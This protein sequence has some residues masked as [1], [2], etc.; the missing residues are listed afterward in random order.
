VCS[1]AAPAYRR[2]GVKLCGPGRRPLGCPASPLP[3][4]RLRQATPLYRAQRQDRQLLPLPRRVGRPAPAHPASPA[5][6][7]AGW[8]PDSWS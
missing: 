4:E 8:A 3:H 2:G 6:A 7:I 1:S 5:T